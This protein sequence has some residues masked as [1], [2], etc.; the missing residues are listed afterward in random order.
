MKGFK[1]RGVSLHFTITQQ[2]IRAVLGYSVKVYNKVKVILYDAIKF[3]L[4]H[5]GLR[6]H[7]HFLESVENHSQN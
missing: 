4:S 6:A 1:I 7:N 5:P 2:T 3:E